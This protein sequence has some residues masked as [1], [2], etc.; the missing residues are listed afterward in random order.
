MAALVAIRHKPT[1]RA[2]HERLLRVEDALGR[3]AR[4]RV[5]V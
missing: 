5:K 2:F 3:L 4:K 1:I